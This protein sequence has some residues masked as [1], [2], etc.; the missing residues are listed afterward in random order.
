VLPATSNLIDA[1]L[2]RN[3]AALGWIGVVLPDVERAPPVVLMQLVVEHTVE[4][5][6]V[7][8]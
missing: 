7:S 6:V 2:Y 1:D 3:G 5:P 4:E 8:T